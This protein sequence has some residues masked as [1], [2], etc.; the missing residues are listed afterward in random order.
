MWARKGIRHA[1]SC[2]MRGAASCLIVLLASGLSAR[3]ETRIERTLKIDAG[4]RLEVETGSG[5]I[6]VTGTS[7]PDVHVVVTSKGRAIEELLTL[8]FD[9]GGKTARIAG[10]K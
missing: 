7:R 5:A 9:E 4:G 2:V 10:R 8:R 3:A 1:K 6:T